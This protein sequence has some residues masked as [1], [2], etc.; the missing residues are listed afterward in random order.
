[1]K[2]REEKQVS[3]VEYELSP[4]KEDAIVRKPEAKKRNTWGLLLVVS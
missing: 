1:M 4:K 3:R 2:S